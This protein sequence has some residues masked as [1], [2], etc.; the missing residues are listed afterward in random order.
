V[1]FSPPDKTVEFT[2][3]GDDGL[4]FTVTDSGSGT[5]I[6]AEDLKRIREPF[7]RTA[8]AAEIPG[9]GLGLAIADQ[10]AT[11]LGGTLTISSSSGGTVATFIIK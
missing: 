9:T 4:H 1:K 8:S 7:F 11:L 5:G 2:I 10:S 6:A 3:A